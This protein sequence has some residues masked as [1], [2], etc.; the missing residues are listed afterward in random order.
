MSTPTLLQQKLYAILPKFGASFSC[1]G[2]IWIILGVSLSDRH[3]KVF[4][5]LVGAMGVFTVIE[6]AAIF[7]GKFFLIE[8]SYSYLQ[9]IT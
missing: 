8:K 6:A 1:L 2:G 5:R 4:H 9:I 7:W 3:K